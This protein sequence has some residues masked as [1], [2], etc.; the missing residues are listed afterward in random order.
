M[1][2]I[3]LKEGTAGLS[4]QKPALPVSYSYRLSA[5]SRDGG[6]KTIYW[7]LCGPGDGNT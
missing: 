3:S 7:L 4:P 6:A 2:A 5:V 1:M